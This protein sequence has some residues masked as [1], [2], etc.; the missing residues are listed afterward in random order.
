MGLSTLQI[1]QLRQL[2]RPI[3]R[4][5]VTGVPKRLDLPLCTCNCNG[6]TR[7]LS[8][9]LKEKAKI[10]SDMLRLCEVR[11]KE[12]LAVRWQNGDSIFLGENEERNNGGGVDFIVRKKWAPWAAS[13]QVHWSCIGPLIINLNEKATLKII[14]MLAPNLEKWRRKDRGTSTNA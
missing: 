4:W 14:Q 11:R 8:P 10:S 5:L 7:V 3:G 1:N 12:D 6:L 2:R 13:F 9:L